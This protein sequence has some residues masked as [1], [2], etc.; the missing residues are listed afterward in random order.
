MIVYDLRTIH[1]TL[2]EIVQQAADEPIHI[3]SKNGRTFV[4]ESADEFEQEVAL[5]RQSPSFMAFLAERSK[6]KG[7]ISLEQ[8]E[9][10]IEE[11]LQQE[12]QSTAE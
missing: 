9:Q 4:L 11:A 5:L 6:Q 7:T 3:I 8:L 1:I 2:D 12:A 10:E